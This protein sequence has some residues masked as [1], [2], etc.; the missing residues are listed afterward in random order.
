VLTYQQRLSYAG[1]VRQQRTL[2]LKKKSRYFYFA[3]TASFSTTSP[4]KAQRP[5]ER[6]CVEV[7]GEVWLYAG[8]I[9]F[10]FSHNVLGPHTQRP[11]EQKAKLKNFC[12]N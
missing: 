5:E 2:R 3:A 6:R 1:K 10:S 12:S 8:K 11:A 4:A 9:F 7:P